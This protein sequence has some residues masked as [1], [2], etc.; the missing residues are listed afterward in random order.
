MNMAQASLVNTHPD[1]QHLHV[2]INLESLKNFTKKRKWRSRKAS[3]AVL[4]LAMG[5]VPRRSRTA[6]LQSGIC[7]R[8]PC[9]DK[10]S[11]MYIL[12]HALILNAL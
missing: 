5:T 12:P 10:V 9:K 3:D 6:E 7:F 11:I 2:P 1:C 4:S 8:F